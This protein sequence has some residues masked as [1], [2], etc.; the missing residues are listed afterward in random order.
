MKNLLICGL[1]LVLA[2]TN[3]AGA[4]I[5][6]S[7]TIVANA[8]DAAGPSNMN[9]TQAADTG[10]IDAIDV[11]TPASSG[12]N[13][14]SCGMVQDW[15][16]CAPAPTSACEVSLE[17]HHPPTP[18]VDSHFLFPPSAMT[19]SS[20]GGSYEGNELS[21]EISLDWSASL[22][23]TFGIATSVQSETLDSVQF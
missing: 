4:E 9:G 23:D 11:G 8:A 5:I 13:T 12:P 16:M 22:D 17:A 18:A 1:L 14:I 10:V 19:V 2:L 21:V 7:W 20:R 3:T 15:M 6:W